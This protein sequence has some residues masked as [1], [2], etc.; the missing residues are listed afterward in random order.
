[1]A[2]TIYI[3]KAKVVEMVCKSRVEVCDYQLSNTTVRIMQE[4]YG[5]LLRSRALLRYDSS[6]A[7][8]GVA[9]L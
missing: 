2:V 9:V 7:M 4:L 1:M 8:L 5:L 3:S 6:L